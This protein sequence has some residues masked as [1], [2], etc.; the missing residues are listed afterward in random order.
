MKRIVMAKYGF[1]RNEDA[2]FHDDGNNFQGWATSPDSRL[3]VSKLVSGG[4]AYLSCD[5]RGNLTHEE[6][7][8][9]PHYYKANW[10]YN[11]E[12]LDD[13][14]DKDLFDFYNACVEYEKEYLEAESKS[15]FPS[16]AEIKTQ[17][18]KINKIRQDEIDEVTTLLQV[19]APNLFKQDASD[20]ELK[21]IRNNYQS[22]LK[23]K[24]DVN[25]YPQ[26]IHKTAYS[27]SFIKPTND[28]LNSSYYFRDLMRT[29]T[30]YQ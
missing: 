12:E 18:E 4:N 30:K 22:L 9:L 15:V 27:K 26:S 6:Y 11:G 23:R 3:R 8:K 29:L 2:D 19:V 14:E 5:M 25:K 20:Y 7:S 16:L 13:L 28:D 21:S 17:C 24:Y 10:G 1:I